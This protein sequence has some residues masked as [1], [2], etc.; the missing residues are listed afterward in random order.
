MIYIYIYIT[1][2]RAR[3]RICGRTYCVCVYVCVLID[4]DR[5][6]V[7]SRPSP[8]LTRSWC[9]HDIHLWSKHTHLHK[10]STCPSVLG[11]N[12]N[13]STNFSKKK[14]SWHGGQHLLFYVFMC[15]YIYIHILAW[16]L[17]Y[18][19]TQ[20]KRTHSSFCRGMRAGSCDGHIRMC[21]R[22]VS[23]HGSHVLILVT[24]NCRQIRGAY[25]RGFACWRLRIAR[26]CFHAHMCR[27]GACRGLH[28]W[29]WHHACPWQQ[30]FVLNSCVYVVAV[31]LLYERFWTGIWNVVFVFAAA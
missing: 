5:R 8:A 9:D 7:N 18:I 25:W 13:F 12:T 24:E 1:C 31:A 17:T 30:I 28:I 10:H 2:I 27:W 16:L 4:K 6:N 22:N 26:A 14:E 20:N 3:V 15:V 21:G 11:P 29:L 23:R 19:H